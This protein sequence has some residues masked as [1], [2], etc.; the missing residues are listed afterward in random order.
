MLS[1]FVCCIC[2][3]LQDS[4]EGAWRSAGQCVAKFDHFCAII[5]TA[6][7]DCNHM[8]FWCADSYALLSSYSAPLPCVSLVPRPHVLARWILRSQHARTR[9]VCRFKYRLYCVLESF[10]ILWALALALDAIF[11]CLLGDSVSKVCCFPLVMQ[12]CYLHP[13]VPVAQLLT[14]LWGLVP[15]L[16]SIHRARQPCGHGQASARS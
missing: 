8:M 13:P 10:L 12:Q 16:R 11:P 14:L 15:E 2:P 7:G 6:V 3:P 9:A 5:A 1:P 4:T